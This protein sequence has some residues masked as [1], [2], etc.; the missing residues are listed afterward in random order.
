MR[1][2]ATESI[3][4]I[5]KEV[6]MLARLAWGNTVVLTSFMI[7]LYRNIQSRQSRT[8]LCLAGCAVIDSRDPCH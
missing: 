2:L 5:C 7:G 1:N 3:L 4:F 8:G 6:E